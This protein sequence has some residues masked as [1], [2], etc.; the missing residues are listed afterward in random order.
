[1]AAGEEQPTARRLVVVS[2]DYISDGDNG[3]L[4]GGGRPEKLAAFLCWRGKK[5]K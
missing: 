3:S 5:K 2:N 4:W 1:M